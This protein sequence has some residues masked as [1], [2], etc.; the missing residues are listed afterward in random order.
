MYEICSKLTLLR[1]RLRSGVFIINF[2]QI[3]HIVLKFLQFTMKSWMPAGFPK[4]IVVFEQGLAY[5]ENET[6]KKAAYN[7]NY[8]TSSCLISNYRQYLLAQS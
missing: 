7:G 1:L 3:S 6:I 8:A 5:R 4:F 2:E